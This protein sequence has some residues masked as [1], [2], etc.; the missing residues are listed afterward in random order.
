MPASR[1]QQVFLPRRG[2]KVS[3]SNSTKI[4]RS[5]VAD[6]WRWLW[7]DVLMRILPLGVIPFLYIFIFHL[8]PSFLGLTLNN[9][10]EQIIVGIV[11]GIVMTAFATAYRMK[12]VGP[13]FRRPTPADQALQAFFYLIINAPVEELFFRGFLLAAVPQWTGWLGWGWLVSTAFYTLYH[14]LGKCNWLSVGCVGLAGIV[15]SIVYLAQPQPYSLPG[16]SL[17]PASPPGAS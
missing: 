4:V 3:T 14:R 11:V 7:P 17:S 16:V 9:L 6:T 5:T 1:T 8:P 2:S 12:I 13:W 15:F 10:R